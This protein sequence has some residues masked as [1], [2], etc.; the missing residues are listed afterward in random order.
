MARVTRKNPRLTSADAAGVFATTAALQAA[1]TSQGAEPPQKLSLTGQPTKKTYLQTFQSGHGFAMTGQL[2][3]S[4]TVNDTTMFALGSQCAR[5]VTKGDGSQAALYKYNISPTID[6][7]DKQFAILV[8]VDKPENLTAF[9]IYLGSGNPT[10]YYN[11]IAINGV[12][13]NDYVEKGKWVWVVFPWRDNVSGTPN[14]AAIQTFQIIAID[15]GTTS[16]T[17]RVQAI[18]S[19]PY[20]SA[21]AVS[22][23][24]DDGYTNQQ[25]AINYAGMKGF[26]CN[27][28]PVAEQIDLG[29]AGNATAMTTEYLQRAQQNFGCLVGLHSD[30]WA[31][32]GMALSDQ[33]DAE[34]ELFF[35]TNRKWLADRGL[36]GPDFFAYPGG[37]FGGKNLTIA[38]RFS[39]SARTTDVRQKETIP[40][41]DPHKQRCLPVGAATT[42]ADFQSE[43][44]AAILGKYHLI[45][46]IHRVD[47][48]NGPSLATMKSV[49]D[50]IEASG[51][52]VIT[53]AQALKAV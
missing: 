20:P 30:T 45:L 41:A 13:T 18:A 39:V 49:I 34:L 35:R 12:N 23:D 7:T 32:H 14:R 21:G 51:I 9:R 27:L 47:G 24:F 4:S 52:R 36:N 11:F 3:A 29:D 15:D 6:F 31:H 33:S 16:V 1:I 53:A 25:D 46:V 17:C 40:P 19:I 37:K 44:D 26:A 22:L 5:L 48:T 42:L 43:I 2:A 38:R 10:P 28:W 8:W 50:Y